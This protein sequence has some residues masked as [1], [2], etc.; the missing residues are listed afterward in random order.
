MSHFPGRQRD[1]NTGEPITVWVQVYVMLGLVLLLLVGGLRAVIGIYR[2]RSMDKVLAELRGEGLVQWE[3]AAHYFGQKS[4]AWPRPRGLG[5]LVLTSRRLHFRLWS[6]Q[7]ELDIPVSAITGMA[8]PLTVR[9]MLG[10]RRAL[11]VIF[12][13][14]QGEEDAA[15]WVVS[16]LAAWQEALIQATGGAIERLR[17]VDVGWWEP[18]KP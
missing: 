18:P 3:P 13:R 8:A 2:R 4:V 5:A 12:N 1:M 7:E 10:P 16:D 9:S 14:Q 15:A 6:P 11:Y 17:A